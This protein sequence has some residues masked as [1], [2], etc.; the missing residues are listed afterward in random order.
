MDRE[1]PVY[2]EK[3]YTSSVA[4]V[5]YPYLGRLFVLFYICLLL[6]YTQEAALGNADLSVGVGRQDVSL[7]ERLSVDITR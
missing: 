2:N 3:Q 1:T 5:G 4:T 7:C 6:G